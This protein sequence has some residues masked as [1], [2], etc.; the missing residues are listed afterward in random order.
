MGPFV[1]C[2]LLLRMYELHQ[3]CISGHTAVK[4]R[5][6]QHFYA[7]P[8]VSTAVPGFGQHDDALTDK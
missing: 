6:V 3:Q 1:S 4:K 7:Q 8:G 2:F 5:L